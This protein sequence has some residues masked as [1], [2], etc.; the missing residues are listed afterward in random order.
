MAAGH[1]AVALAGLAVWGAFAIAR[2]AALAWAAAAL[3]I[4]AAGL[5]MAVLLMS[6]PE[7]VAAGSE[8]A[9]G[10]AAGPA[11]SRVLSIA[12]HV[13]LAVVT[14]LLVVLAATGAA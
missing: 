8:P 14:M 12:S 10:R 2:G 9:D 3:V 4:A 5:G 1:A 11:P 6:V 7:P 13:M